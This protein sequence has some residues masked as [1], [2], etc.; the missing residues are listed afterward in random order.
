M[1]LLFEI[2][3]EKKIGFGKIFNF[4][5]IKKILVYFLNILFVIKLDI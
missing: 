1:Y 5:C 2:F 3:L 4:L